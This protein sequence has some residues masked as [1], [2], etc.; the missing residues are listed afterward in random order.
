MRLGSRP[1]QS[2]TEM[3]HATLSWSTI[4]EHYKEH[5]TPCSVSSYNILPL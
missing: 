1:L 2:H 5:E 3:E 4:T